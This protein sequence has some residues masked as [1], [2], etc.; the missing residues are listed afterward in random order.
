MRIGVDDRFGGAM[1]DIRGANAYSASPQAGQTYD[2]DISSLLN[3]ENPDAAIMQTLGNMSKSD[4]NAMLERLKADGRLPKEA[5]NKLQ[6]SIDSRPQAQPQ[7]S[8]PANYR[9]T[10]EDS[11]KR[12]VETGYGGMLRKA[13]LQKNLATK[14]AG[15]A[16]S[17]QGNGGAAVEET[18]GPPPGYVQDAKDAVDSRY[19]EVQDV[20][21]RIAEGSG[22]ASDADKAAW[23]ESQAKL[24]DSMNELAARAGNLPL[25]SPE[26]AAAKDEL[27]RISQQVTKSE[28]PVL[29]KMNPEFGASWNRFHSKAPDSEGAALPARMKVYG[30]TD[31]QLQTYITSGKESPGLTRAIA[32][33]KRTGEWPALGVTRAAFQMR[34]DYLR[35]TSPDNGE[36]Q[37][38][39]ADLD[40]AAASLSQNRSAIHLNYG[41]NTYARLANKYPDEATRPKNVQQQITEAKGAIASV[42]K[43]AAE[44]V[45]AHP[46][47]YGKNSATRKLAGDALSLEA[48]IMTS[49][50]KTSMAGQAKELAK[51]AQTQTGAK[52]KAVPPPP[53]LHPD[54]VEGGAVDKK[55]QAAL[56]VDPSLGD[57]ARGGDRA[58]NF[59]REGIQNQKVRL[60]VDEQQVAHLA[61]KKADIPPQLVAKVNKQQGAIFDSALATQTKLAN[62]KPGT[63]GV[64]QTQLLSEMDTELS[65]YAGKI[66]AA[67]REKSLV[68]SSANLSKFSEDAVKRGKEGLQ[69]NFES[70]EQKKMERVKNELWMR[71]AS[72]PGSAQSEI[73]EFNNNPAEFAKKQPDNKEETQ[74]RSLFNDAFKDVNGQL[75]EAKIRSADANKA[76]EYTTKVDDLDGLNRDPELVTGLATD[77]LKASEAHMKAIP[78]KGPERLPRLQAAMDHQAAVVAANSVVRDNADARIQR[79]NISHQQVQLVY[80]ST[81]GVGEADH[82]GESAEFVAKVTTDETQVKRD[83]FDA[84]RGAA[85]ESD[86]LRQS[87]GKELDA[88]QTKLPKRVQEQRAPVLQA[89]KDQLAAQQVRLQGSV[90]EM[91]ADL[92][93]K[94]SQAQL[95]R[96]E[97]I[98]KQEMPAVQVSRIDK[99]QSAV[100]HAR[101]EM[102]AEALADLGESSLAVAKRAQ[103]MPGVQYGQLAVDGLGGAHRSVMNLRETLTIDGGGA[104]SATASKEFHAAMKDRAASIT[105]E[106]DEMNKASDV[107]ALADK[108]DSVVVKDYEEFSDRYKKLREAVKDQ[109]GSAFGF[110]FNTGARLRGLIDGKGGDLNAAAVRDGVEGLDLVASNAHDQVVQLKF[111]AEQMRQMK[112]AGIPDQ[113]IM[114][115]LRDPRLATDLNGSQIKDWRS[116]LNTAAKRYGASAPEQ[117]Y[118]L[119]I[120]R[121][122]SPVGKVLDG[123]RSNR[124]DRFVDFLGDKHTDVLSNFQKGVQE[125]FDEGQQKWSG[126]AP[127]A[128]LTQAPDQVILAM[129]SSYALAGVFA[130]AAAF[131]RIP[132]AFAAAR[133]LAAGMSVPGRLAVLGGVNLAEAGLGM[134]T[135]QAISKVGTGVFGEGSFGAKA[136]ETIGGGF[137]L[138]VGS[139]VAMR[140]G[141]GF[142]AA[143]GLTMHGV[144]VVA[145]QLGASPELAANIGMAA[146][147]FVPAV[148]GTMGNLHTQRRAEGVMHEFGINPKDAKALMGDVFHAESQAGGGLDV[149]RFTRERAAKLV[150]ERF[151]ELG[152][153]ARNTLVDNLTLDAVR[154]KILF[155]P[156]KTGTPEQYAREV[157]NYFG[158]MKSELIQKG[159]S[160]QRATQLVTSEKTAMYDEALA[161]TNRAMERDVHPGASDDTPEN[162]ATATRNAAEQLA[163]N[164][165]QPLRDVEILRTVQDK[166][167]VVGQQ[168]ERGYKFVGWEGNEKA[169]V[170]DPLGS[171]R[172]VDSNN[173]VF[174]HDSQALGLM[175]PAVKAQYE[176]RLASMSEPEKVEW[177]NML[178]E[179]NKQSPEHVQLIRQLFAGGS[180]MQDLKQWHDWAQGIPREQLGAYVSPGAL[181]QHLKQSCVAACIQKTEAILFPDRGAQLRDVNIQ[182]HEQIDIMKRNWGGSEPRGAA[183]SRYPHTSAPPLQPHEWVPANQFSFKPKVLSAALK[184]EGKTDYPVYDVGHLDRRFIPQQLEKLAGAE[185]AFLQAG[186][187]QEGKAYEVRGVR[188]GPDG[189]EVMVRAVGQENGSWMKVKDLEPKDGIIFLPDG[190]VVSHVA[191]APEH[192]M[193]A[194]KAGINFVGDPEFLN[195]VR[196]ATGKELTG[197]DVKGEAALKMIYDSVQDIGIAGVSVRWRS[198]NKGHQLLVVGAKQREGQYVFD[199]FDPGSGKTRSLAGKDLIA[200]RDGEGGG[201]GDIRSVH[202]PKDV[203]I[204]KTGNSDSTRNTGRYEYTGPHEFASVDQAVANLEVARTR[205]DV[206]SVLASAQPGFSAVDAQTRENMINLILA[207]SE[208][209]ARRAL[210]EV[211]PALSEMPQP[212]REFATERLRSMKPDELVKT[213]QRLEFADQPNWSRVSEMDAMKFAQEVFGL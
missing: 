122:F 96:G 130:R 105:N 183:D 16:Q 55:R 70:F 86:K 114:S 67:E 100:Q 201:F 175:K 20:G 166:G 58:V 188:P 128:A 6:K 17:P 194:A 176:R 97:E 142:Q 189:N 46:E 42:G 11:S 198:N 92:D 186:N 33:S 177:S 10:R 71:A 123:A 144:P 143:L 172:K 138:S 104:A 87:I 47:H 139:A 151:P 209:N 199:V 15:P 152:H 72:H 1:T 196:G 205:T 159:V 44:K 111:A 25:D 124:T 112:A 39:A 101:N 83:A 57:V 145:Q 50:A 69:K 147:A 31:E 207:N 133:G 148:L 163:N 63:L 56:K 2:D 52:S 61:S 171:I 26:R 204:P 135:G 197:R 81:P 65:T 21:K 136:F 212:A 206:D 75:D 179:A 158:N 168:S 161:K 127:I 164:T 108:I 12:R 134:A 99:N 43:H 88:T 146:G 200:Y 156:P 79:A 165:N 118:S 125:K 35:A 49:E 62:E 110:L 22:P 141:L 98:I 107:K 34:A 210:L 93:P 150:G 19:A 77:A 162:A 103:T 169:I 174:V 54:L 149:E 59:T 180:N 84:A 45:E 208:P 121:G 64:A 60:S 173:V 14:S 202:V 195:M 29:A 187:G 30:V 126:I 181:A 3:S 137:Q 78:Q 80:P 193:M 32:D 113:V 89:Q 120:M 53:A 184:Q 129:A 155:D 74:L 170:Q 211:M 94:Q 13:E 115:A 157:E 132:Q 5:L 48:H 190:S 95:Q 66:S 182:A 154:K 24:R 106:V 28:L 41:A 191:V 160:P 192:P 51:S 116:D 18:P 85:D 76:L 23:T 153:D 131:T 8:A 119:R 7:Q 37:K 185:G 213:A 140:S 91:G 38:Q 203:P 36:A 68:K 9:A 82:V 90:A 109:R 167:A 73:E 27:T 102:R 178:G 40:G 117:L 4:A